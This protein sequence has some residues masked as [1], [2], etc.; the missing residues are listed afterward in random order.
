MKRRFKLS[1]RANVISISGY[2]Y[3]LTEATALAKL[4]PN[5]LRAKIK[6]KL[7]DYVRWSWNPVTGD[8]VIGIV[9]RHINQIPESD[10]YPIGAWVRGFYFIR[11]NLIAI[12]PWFWPLTSD[13]DFSRK[14]SDEI[15]SVIGN[16]L[17]H[18]LRKSRIEYNV[19][20]NWL[21]QTFHRYATSW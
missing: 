8:L 19:D 10:V 5:P 12:R 2:D 20:N 3:N 18:S 4:D 14:D 17:Q 13:E 16:L 9:H 21:K 7:A 6:N 11:E 1:Q 15:C